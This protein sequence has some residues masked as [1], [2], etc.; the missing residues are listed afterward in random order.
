[1]MG[2]LAGLASGRAMTAVLVAAA[3]AAFAGLWFWR[4]MAAIDGMITDARALAI[5]ERDAHWRAEIAI[6]NAEAEQA[7]AEQVINA[8]AADGAAQLQIAALK[9][10]LEQMEAVNAS[11]P[12]GDACGLGHE[13]VRL[14]S[15]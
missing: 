11:L 6:S 9:S 5:V 10:E 2:L 1:M 3:L 12:N 15:R 7:R 4:G 14:L 13:R 8:A